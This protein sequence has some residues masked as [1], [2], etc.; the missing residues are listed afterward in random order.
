MLADHAVI[1]ANCRCE[2]EF[3]SKS[4]SETLIEQE[5]M[6]HGHVRLEE[7]RIS[8]RVEKILR[9]IEL[10]SLG[11]PISP[12]YIKRPEALLT[13]P[14]GRQFPLSQL[15]GATNVNIQGLLLLVD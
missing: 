5:R 3:G 14:K 12:V 4:V 9:E 6:L 7:D 1:R 13:R 15:S 11:S 10:K 2:R 8:P